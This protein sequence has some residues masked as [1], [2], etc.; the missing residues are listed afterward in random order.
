M[1]KPMTVSQLTDI[2]ES[3]RCLYGDAPITVRPEPAEPFFLQTHGHYILD[4]MRDKDMQ[5]DAITLATLSEALRGLPDTAVIHCN[6]RVTKNTQIG[7]VTDEEGFVETL[8]AREIGRLSHRVCI[9][10]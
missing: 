9:G 8:H 7:I 4:C 5:E 1:P 3:Q 2:V 10:A 6:E